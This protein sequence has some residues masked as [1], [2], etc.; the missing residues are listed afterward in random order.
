MIRACSSGTDGLKLS[1]PLMPHF[2]DMAFKLKINRDAHNVIAGSDDDIYEF[3]ANGILKVTI[4]SVETYYAPGRW[5]WV[6]T[7]NDHKSGPNAHP[8]PRRA[9]HR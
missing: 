1:G 7:H 2:P 8:A 6:S 5:E 4:R 3:Q 9:E